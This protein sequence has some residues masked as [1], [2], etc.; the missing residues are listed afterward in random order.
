MTV[1]MVILICFGFFLVQAAFA[2]KAVSADFASGFEKEGA[3][4]IGA[5]GDRVKAV[6][7][8]LFDA[9]FYGGEADGIFGPLTLT[10]VNGFQEVHN[11]PANGIIDKN[12]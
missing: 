4:S 7:K 11:L 10:A 12:T 2:P 8:L 6:Q 1:K 3:I 5:R 9:Y